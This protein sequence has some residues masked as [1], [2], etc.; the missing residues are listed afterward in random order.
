MNIKITSGTLC[1]LA[2]L[3]CAAHAVPAAQGLPPEVRHR[4]EAAAAIDDPA[5]FEKAVAEGLADPDPMVWRYAFALEVAGG[6]V[7]VTSADAD[8]MIPVEVVFAGGK[9]RYGVVAG[10]AWRHDFGAAGSVQVR[11]LATG[12]VFGK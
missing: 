7:T 5:R 6:E 10:G 3:P 2:L 9:P 11:N 8:V 12:E 4:R 1:L